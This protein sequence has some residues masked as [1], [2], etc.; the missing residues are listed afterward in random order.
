MGIRA[1]CLDKKELG[2]VHVFCALCVGADALC[3]FLS[4]CRFSWEVIMITLIN[5]P[6]FTHF[7]INPLKVTRDSHF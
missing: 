4:R 2:S 5:K 6:L 7:S 1:L 3:A